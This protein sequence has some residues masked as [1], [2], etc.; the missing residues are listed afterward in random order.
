M[1]DKKIKYFANFYQ[2]DIE[3]EFQIDPK[4]FMNNG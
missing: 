4:I 3:R 2:E 1:Y